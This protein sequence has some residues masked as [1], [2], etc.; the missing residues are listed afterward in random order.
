MMRFDKHY[1]GVRIM[2][3]LRHLLSKSWFINK[4]N[5]G[6]KVQ[7]NKSP[8]SQEIAKIIEG[9]LIGR[10]PKST[11]KQV[12][13]K[14]RDSWNHRGANYWQRSKKLLNCQSG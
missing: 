10:D 2:F 14:S 6:L 11:A 7:P 13:Y 3:G 1:Q 8:P 9:Q 5:I 4:L 12:S